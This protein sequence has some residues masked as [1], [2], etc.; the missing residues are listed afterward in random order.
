MNKKDTKRNRVIIIIPTHND[1][2]IISNN[3]NYIYNFIKKDFFELK[4]YQIVVIENGS[5]DKTKY[6]CMNLQKKYQDIDFLFLKKSGRGRALKYVM[7]RYKADIYCYMDS[8]LSTKIKYLKPLIKNIGKYDIVMGSRYHKS[9]KTK[10]LVKRLVISKV[11]NKLAN[12]LFNSPFLDLECGFK[13]F[14]K[15]CVKEILPLVQDYYW[16]FDTEMILFAYNKGFK[17]C[18]IPIEWK[19]SKKTS[20]NIISDVFHCLGGLIKLKIKLSRDK[21]E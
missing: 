12:L 1:E 3:I 13:G 18:E 14:N 20:V 15:R 9:S 19:E 4:N 8:D 11:Y 21:K 10:R 16:F 7:Q 5:K 2:E 6:I 17:I